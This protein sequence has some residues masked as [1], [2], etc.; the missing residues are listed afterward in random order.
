MGVIGEGIAAYAQPLVD[1]TDG[2]REQV[3]KAL[4]IAMVCWNLGVMD[5]SEHAEVLR[6]MRSTTTMSDPE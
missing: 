3:E 1:R 5:D 4:A 6:D 2:S